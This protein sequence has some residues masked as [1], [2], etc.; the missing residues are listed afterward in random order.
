[1]GVKVE[2]FAAPCNRTSLIGQLQALLAGY[3]S[4]SIGKY[5]FNERTFSPFRI[6]RYMVTSSFDEETLG[7]IADATWNL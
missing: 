4:L 7:G 6:K 2:H 1:L 5:T 3:R